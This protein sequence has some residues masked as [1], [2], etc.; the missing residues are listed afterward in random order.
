[1]LKVNYAVGL[2]A[3]AAS[4]GSGVLYDLALA[5]VPGSQEAATRTQIESALH[6]VEKLLARDASAEEIV[7][8]LYADDALLTGEGAAGSFRGRA[9]VIEDVAEWKKGLGP[10]GSKTCKYAI[11]DPVV[12]SKTVFSSFLLLT[13][14]ANPPVMPKDQTLRML[15]TWTRLP[16]GWRV[17]LEQY[18]SGVM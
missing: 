15:Y 13:C 4:V 8:L 16:Q 14:K 12:A 7:G 5:A 10:G 1:M 6:A 17:I 3:L 2:A 18:E 11:V 9:A